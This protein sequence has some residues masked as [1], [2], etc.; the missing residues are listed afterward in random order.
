[1]HLW[2]RSEHELKA[3]I[4]LD[5]S[6]LFFLN[7]QLSHFNH[8]SVYFECSDCFSLKLHIMT[9]INLNFIQFYELFFKVN[10]AGMSISM[11]LKSD[12]STVCDKSI[13]LKASESRLQTYDLIKCVDLTGSE[14]L[15]DVCCESAPH[16]D[17]NE[18]HLKDKVNC[19][20]IWWAKCWCV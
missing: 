4:I 3:H 12:I 2:E 20:Y 11:M 17:G 8:D 16:L 15:L 9:L 5:S 1:M 6:F 10:L 13:T 19:S 18:V 14:E 7:F